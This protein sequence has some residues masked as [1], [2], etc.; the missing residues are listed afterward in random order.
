MNE[1][2]ELLY[3]HPDVSYHTLSNGFVLELGEFKVEL[4]SS[5]P[6]QNLITLIG[7]HPFKPDYK[8]CCKKLL[9]SRTS[10]NMMLKTLLGCGVLLRASH[11]PNAIQFHKKSSFGHFQEP[12][13]APSQSPSVNKFSK[14]SNKVIRPPDPSHPNPLTGL[15]LQRKSKRKFE[16]SPLQKSELLSILHCGYGITYQDD[17]G[18]FHHTVPSAGGIYPL[19]LIVISKNISKQ[20]PGI[21]EFLPAEYRLKKITSELTS[22]EI[23]E[24]VFRTQHIDY[25]SSAAIIFITAQVDDMLNKYGERGYRYLLLEAGHVAQ[26]LILG[27]LVH[28][29]SSIPV[30]GFDDNIV[31]WALNLNEGASAAMYCLVLGR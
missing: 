12:H 22:N 9:I 18:F 30:G 7:P 28:D 19:K 6:W 20:I 4:D 14:K 1:L 16:T 26:N 15:L 17:E 29:I 10:L 25:S 23:I 3:V 5:L 8:E 24:C 2:S 13:Y 27:S 31:N 21:Y 11:A